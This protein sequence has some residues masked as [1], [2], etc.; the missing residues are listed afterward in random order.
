MN[1]EFR[2]A[3]GLYLSRIPTF[4]WKECGE[5][6]SIARPLAT[7]NTLEHLKYE[8]MLTTTV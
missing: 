3:H 1:G 5:G 7:F 6:T 2:R 4:I 8:V